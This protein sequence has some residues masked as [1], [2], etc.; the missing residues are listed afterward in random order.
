MDKKV[1]GTMTLEE[2]VDML[3]IYILHE[4]D[5]EPSKNEGA[6]ECAIRIMR[7]SKSES[8]TLREW[9]GEDVLNEKSGFHE[10]ALKER[11]M[12]LSEQ[13]TNQLR[14]Q[15]LTK[16]LKILVSTLSKWR[17]EAAQLEEENEELKRETLTTDEVGRLMGILDRYRERGPRDLATS[18]AMLLRKLERFYAL[19][20]AEEREN[21][22]IEPPPSD[23][24]ELLEMNEKG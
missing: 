7:E 16:P 13:I 24:G 21:R 8:Q 14:I 17:D 19:L 23:S 9:I 22:I 2:Q 11:M 1:E 20:T 3:A 10:V 4:V 18:D 6:I 5:G 15:G 12:K